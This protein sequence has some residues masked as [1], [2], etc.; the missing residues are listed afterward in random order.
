MFI[1]H[2]PKNTG[3]IYFRR[4]EHS[5][6]IHIATEAYTKRVQR[7]QSDSTGNIKSFLSKPIGPNE[8]AQKETKKIPN[9]ITRTSSFEN[10]TERSQNY[11][12]VSSL[13]FYF[14]Q[15]LSTRIL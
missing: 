6:R 13:K 11:W 9:P 14:L 7:T 1:L 10:I 12:H 15:T 4:N 5:A 2:I 8:I 3:F